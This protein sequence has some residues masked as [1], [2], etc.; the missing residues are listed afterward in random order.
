MRKTTHEVLKKWC[1]TQF[2]VWK[3]MSDGKVTVWNALSLTWTQSV[4]S[5]FYRFI[6]NTTNTFKQMDGGCFYNSFPVDSNCS[7]HTQTPAVRRFQSSSTSTLRDLFPAPTDRFL[8]W[9]AKGQITWTSEI[10]TH[11]VTEVNILL[12]NIHLLQI[13]G[14]RFAGASVSHS[15]VFTHTQLKQ[16]KHTQKY[17]CTNRRVVQVWNKNRKKQISTF[18]MISE[19]MVIYH[20]ICNSDVVKFRSIRTVTEFF[21]PFLLHTTTVDLKIVKLRAPA[22]KC[23]WTKWPN[24]SYVIIW[25]RRHV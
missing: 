5:Y 7:R 24:I 4:S 9:S 16:V 8:L 18:D 10:F 6:E 12:I 22:P 1:C 25:F 2:T 21:S 3:Q 11:I 15:S 23:V 14:V 17:L 13:Q 20:Y 19:R